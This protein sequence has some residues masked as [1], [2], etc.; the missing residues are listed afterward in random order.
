MGASG[1]VSAVVA[2]VYLYVPARDNF[3]DG[4]PA[5]AGLGAWSA[6]GWVEIY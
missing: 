5:N 1:A 2:T 6:I 4:D 3:A